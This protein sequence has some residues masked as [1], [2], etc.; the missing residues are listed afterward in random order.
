MTSEFLQMF[1][2][3]SPCRC[4][5]DGTGIHRCHAGRDPRYPGG[6]C[7]REA[8]PRFIATPG[9]L[10]GMQ[11]KMSMALACYCDECHA[12]AFPSR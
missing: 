10:A 6:Q 9:S 11:A 12:E 1:S 8:K 5:F 2:S 4:G 3:D 7:E